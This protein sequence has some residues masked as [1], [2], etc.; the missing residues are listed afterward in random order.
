MSSTT[1]YGGGKAMRGGV[2]ICWPQFNTRG[3]H[4]KHGFAR[5]SEWSVV[6]TSEE[7]YPSVI[8]ALQSDSPFSYSLTYA[9]SLD[10]A[11]SISTALT[12]RNSGDKPLEF[13]SALHTYFRIP[14]RTC[15]IRG[16]Q[17]LN[18]EDSTKGGEVAVQEVDDLPIVGEVDR[19]YLKTPAEA[20]LIEGERAIKVLK[21]GF[22][23][24]VVWNIGSE[25]APELKDLGP[26]E[27]EQYV[28]YEAGA[29][30]KPVK[31]A[32]NM[33]WTG[34]QTFTRLAASDVPKMKPKSTAEAE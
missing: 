34:G 25:R 18:Y 4:G 30:A 2:P 17:G 20:F 6:R 19:V 8:L 27:W 31:V 3:P 7:P 13:T 15:V 10:S 26:G 1:A 12:V 11:D 23:E 28:C 29:I 32:P 21:I 9:V 24:A 16:L 33:S 22:P 14:A 5:N